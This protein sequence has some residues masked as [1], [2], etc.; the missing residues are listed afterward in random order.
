MDRR[1]GRTELCCGGLRA[2]ADAL[3]VA[4]HQHVRR[5]AA[6]DVSLGFARRAEEDRT[7]REG[8]RPHDR[9]FEIDI[10]LV[11]V[12]AEVTDLGAVLLPGQRPVDGSLGWQVG[13]E[14][15]DRLLATLRLPKRVPLGARRQRRDA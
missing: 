9:T 4:F 5:G 2:A 1:R 14:V 8:V 10:R 7:G 12:R 13:A 6:R 3:A 15:G 11:A